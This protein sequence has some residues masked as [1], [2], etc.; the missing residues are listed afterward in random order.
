MGWDYQLLTSVLGVT[1]LAHHLPDVARP[2][3]FVL[4]ATFFAIGLSIYD[5]MGRRAYGAFMAWSIL[6]PCFLVLVG[7]LL[8]LRWRRLH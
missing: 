4:L 6:T 1:L 8:H 3:R 7:Y 2:W 5:V